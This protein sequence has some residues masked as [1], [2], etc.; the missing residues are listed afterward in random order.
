M[1]VLR[2]TVIALGL[3]LRSL[4]VELGPS[5]YEFTFRAGHAGSHPPT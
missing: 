2:E 1:E 3:P 4:E 5:Q